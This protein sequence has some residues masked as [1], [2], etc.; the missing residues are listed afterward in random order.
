MKFHATVESTGKNTTGIEVPADVVTEL[1]G[2]KR[3]PVRVTLNGHTYRTTIGVMAGRSLISVSA[4]VRQAAAVA[5]G[6]SIEV[7]LDLDTAARELSVPADLA[8]LM[9]SDTR[10]FFD[11]LSYS[12]RQQ[13]VLPIEQ[14]KTEETRQRR[15][16]KAIAALRERKPQP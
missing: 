3:P 9:D 8:T 1:G 10:Q 16:T 5:A 6:Q 13:F 7:E 2:G 12:R 4:A 11:A 14:A 15:I